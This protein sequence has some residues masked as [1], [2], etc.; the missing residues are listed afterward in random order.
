MIHLD[1]LAPRTD[2]T[3][4]SEPLCP[5]CCC[6]ISAAYMHM[7][8]KADHDIAEVANALANVTLQDWE[9]WQEELKHATI[10]VPEE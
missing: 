7:H 6:C 9:D 10:V 5:V 2:K 3:I 8:L 4:R 1:N